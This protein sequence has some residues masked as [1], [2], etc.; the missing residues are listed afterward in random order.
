MGITFSGGSARGYAH[1]G[2]LK[3]LTEHQLKPDI[4]SGTSMG[5]VVGV[6]Y[7][8]GYNP[9]KIRE[10]LIKE[11]FSKVTGFSWRGPGL[12]NMTK[13]KVVMKEYIPEDDFFQP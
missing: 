10:I 13:L 9:D 7:A 8:A 11:T 3:A 2:V 5:A 4:I 1:I 12:L 6:L